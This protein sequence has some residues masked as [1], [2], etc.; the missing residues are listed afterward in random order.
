MLCIS[1]IPL[2]PISKDCLVT[3]VAFSHRQAFGR[4]NNFI[5]RGIQLVLKAFFEKNVG[6]PFEFAPA[7]YYT[8]IANLKGIKVRGGISRT[9]GLLELT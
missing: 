3:K 6:L 9:A 5:C 2:G 4:A 7:P 8:R 1:T